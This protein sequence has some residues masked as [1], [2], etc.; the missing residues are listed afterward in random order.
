MYFIACFSTALNLL[1]LRFGPRVDENEGSE[2]SE[3][4]DPHDVEFGQVETETVDKP[5]YGGAV[6]SP[7]RDEATP[8]RSSSVRAVR[9]GVRASRPSLMS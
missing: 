7:R 4:G 2:S 5:F 3:G 6:A 9:R 8:L 1:I